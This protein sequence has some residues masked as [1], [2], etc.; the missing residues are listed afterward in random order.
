M[1]Y[2]KCFFNN[3]VYLMLNK[4]RKINLQM[5]IKKYKFN[6]EKIMF[7]NIIISKFDLRINSEKIKIIVN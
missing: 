4:F 2:F 3:Y 7:L 5:N 1:I 6:V